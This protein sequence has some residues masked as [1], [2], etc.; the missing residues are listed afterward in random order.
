MMS[1]YLLFATKNQHALVLKHMTSQTEVLIRV[2][3]LYI[4]SL[5]VKRSVIFRNRLHESNC[6]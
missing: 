6:V 2:T 3:V 5:R 1:F 4:M